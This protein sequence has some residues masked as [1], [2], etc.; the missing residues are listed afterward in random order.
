MCAVNI[1]FINI[2]SKVN[3]YIR[4]LL[5]KLHVP[6]NLIKRSSIVKQRSSHLMNVLH[7]VKCNLN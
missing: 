1:A 7:A 3:S 5:N 2:N 6:N 4:L